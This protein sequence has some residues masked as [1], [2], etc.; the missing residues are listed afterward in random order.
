LSLHKIAAAQ[1]GL[2][3]QYRITEKWTMPKPKKRGRPRL[4]DGPSEVLSVR[5]STA[6]RVRIERWQKRKRIRDRSEAIRELIER[7][8]A[9]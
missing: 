4:P 9:K 8:L 5:M 6:L 1:G 2:E 3:T 7:G